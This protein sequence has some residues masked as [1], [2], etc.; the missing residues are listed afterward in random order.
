MI[1]MPCPVCAMRWVG[2][3]AP[4]DCPVCAGEARLPIN[5]VVARDLGE[6]GHENPDSLVKGRD[7]T[8]DLVER[9]ARVVSAG[10]WL[11]LA[12]A[13]RD[14]RGS[15]RGARV[16]G[17]RVSHWW[18]ANVLGEGGNRHRKCMCLFPMPGD[19]ALLGGLCAA[20]ER[21]GR[22]RV[23]YG[24]LPRLSASGHPSDFALLVDPVDLDSTPGKRFMVRERTWRQASRLE[25]AVEEV[26]SD[27][28][29]VGPA[30]AV[31]ERV[32]A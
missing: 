23:A 16:L 24:R 7:F 30:G 15:G 6:Q 18:D 31:E 13:A 1:H 25:L 32:A 2:G 21:V 14:A 28:V 10:V 9:G 11:G 3:V 26:A 4:K 27:W 5:P 22:G 19:G 29:S 20:H 12:R 8:E 17:E